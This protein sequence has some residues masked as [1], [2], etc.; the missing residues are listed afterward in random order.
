LNCNNLYVRVGRPNDV[1]QSADSG[2]SSAESDSDNGSPSLSPTAE[3]KRHDCVSPVNES[4]L[5]DDWE[6]VEDKFTSRG[7]ELFHWASDNSLRIV[8]GAIPVGETWCIRGQMHTILDQFDEYLS[9]CKN[10]NTFFSDN[11]RQYCS[12][13]FELH[14]VSASDAQDQPIFLSRSTQF[15]KPVSITMRYAAMGGSRQ[16]LHVF[17]VQDNDVIQEITIGDANDKSRE[18]PY[19][20]LDDDYVT[21]RT[22]HFSYYFVCKC[23]EQPIKTNINFINALVYGRI[24]PERDGE[25]THKAHVDFGLQF[26]PSLTILPE[27]W[28]V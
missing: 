15:D 4:K 9:L 22:K 20:L 1:S 18:A 7:G 23:G 14:I 3:A 10:Y 12:S 24:Y 11:V 13:V 17:C 6:H 26:I 8:S 16:D 28:Q 25:Y 5:S 27:F 19:F 21:I 2:L